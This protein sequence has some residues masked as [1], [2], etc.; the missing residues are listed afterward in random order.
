MKKTRVIRIETVEIRRVR[1]SGARVAACPVCGIDRLMVTPEVAA[2]ALGITVR[3]VY[4]AF[5]AGDLHGV[6]WPDGSVGICTEK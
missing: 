4:R 6:D 3:E 5:E 2:T 1:G